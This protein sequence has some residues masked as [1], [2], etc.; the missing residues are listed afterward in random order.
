MALSAAVSIDDLIQKLRPF[1]EICA[2]D[3]LLSFNAGHLANISDQPQIA[4]YRFL[5]C[6]RR[7]RGDIQA[8]ACAITSAMKIGQADV[9]PLLMESAYFYVG[10]G[11]HE[12][13]LKSFPLPAGLPT[14][15]GIQFQQQ[16]IALIRATEIKSKEPVTMRIHGA[17]KTKILNAGA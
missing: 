9:L 4:M 17:S 7:N 12:A 1:L 14:D 13:I 8:W 3:P 15:A 5:T 2:I 6:A 10:E 16:L 11:L